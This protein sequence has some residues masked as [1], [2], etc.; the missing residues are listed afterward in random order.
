M[1]IDELIEKVV[2]LLYSQL[3]SHYVPHKMWEALDLV[4]VYTKPRGQPPDYTS[5]VVL[6]R[7]KS[8]IEDFC[9]SIH[10]EIAKQLK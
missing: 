4:W 5:P 3:N 10:K 8:S 6:K 9:N 7:G 2:F 1:N